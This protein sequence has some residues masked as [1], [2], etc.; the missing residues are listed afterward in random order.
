MD[1]Q[2]MLGTDIQGINRD[3][4]DSAFYHTDVDV[5]SALWAHASSWSSGSKMSPDW[6][7]KSLAARMWEYA[8]DLGPRIVWP[9]EGYANCD[10][11][12]PEG[13]APAF[14]ESIGALTRVTPIEPVFQDVFYFCE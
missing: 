12:D 4:D 5:N 1:I 8:H 2:T 6:T 13:I 14:R 3:L 7:T 11:L 9:P 10:E